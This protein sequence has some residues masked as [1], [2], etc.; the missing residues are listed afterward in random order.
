[1]TRFNKGTLIAL[2][3]TFIWSTTAIFIRYLRYATTCRLLCW[4]S[5]GTGSG[6]EYGEYSLPCLPASGSPCR[7]E[8]RFHHPLWICSLSCPQ[9][10]LD[11]F[12][13]L[14][15]RSGF[16]LSWLTDP[17]HSLAL[18]G[19]ILFKERLETGFKTL[20][21]TASIIGCVFVSGAHDPSTGN[22]IRQAF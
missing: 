20:A 19:R 22:L 16:I 17:P 15:R 18:F 11:H 12:C 6:G 9:R 5:G 4:P 8:L 10:H 13:P 3:G 1:M 2:V 21:V 7:P 14:E